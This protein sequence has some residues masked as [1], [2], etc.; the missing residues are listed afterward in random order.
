[1]SIFQKSVV[2]KYLKSLDDE[3]IN[4][5]FERF[6]NFYGNKLRLY[7]ILN[8]KEENYQEGFLR[9][10]FV[11]VLGYTINPDINYNLTTE[12][13]NQTDNKKADG[14]ILK[15]GVAIA[16]I[17]LKSTK[18]PNLESIT[19]QA[20]NYK[21]NQSKCRYVITSNFHSLRFFIDNATEFEEFN[22]FDLSKDEFKRFYLFLS[23]E[24]ILNEIPL[25]LKQETEFHEESISDKFYKDYKTY[26]ENIYSSL[27]KNNTQ[28]D[29]VILY[30]KTQKLLDRILF[31]LFAEDTGLI[32]PNAI[33]RTI[34]KWKVMAN[35][36]MQISLY[37]RFQALFLHLNNG[38]VYPNWGEVPAYNGGLFFPD[39]I[40]DNPDL[41]IENKFLETDSLILAAYDFSSEIDVNILGHIFEHSLNEFEEVA[42]LIQGETI[43]KTKTKRKKDG[44]FYTPKY[45]TK[46]IIE[47]TI[48]SYCS[49]KKN[50]L[51]ISNLEISEKHRKNNKQTKEGK[52]LFAKLS[53]YKE[54]LFNLKIIDPACG[55]GAF[56]IEALH[57]LIS[58]H[59]EIDDKISEL[60]NKT[61]RFF[62]TDKSILEKN[63]YG[64]DI[65]E[66]SV[67]IAKLSLWLNTAKKERKLS[68]LSG[69]IKCG[70]SLIDNKEIAGEKAFDWNLEFPE[71]MQNGGFDIII[72]NP[73][74]VSLIGKHGHNTV[75]EITQ[76]WLINHFGSNT[77]LPNLFEIF[78]I[79]SLSLLKE[80]GF[81]SF[82]V[83]DR[84]G[85]NASFNYL[86]E[87]V[88]QNYKLVEVIYKWD[89][90][91]IITDTMTFVIQNRKEEDYSITIKSEPLNGFINFTK[92]QLLTKQDF[93]F[94]AYKSQTAKSL[95]DKMIASS[96][97][98]REVC[99][100][101]SGFGG[102]SELI[103][104][105]QINTKQ[106]PVFKGSSIQRY[107]IKENY[108][109]E[110]IPENITGRTTDK[111]K[112]SAKP[113]IL[114]R[115]TGNTIIASYDENGVF[116]EQSLYFIYNLNSN[117]DFRYILAILNSDLITWFFIN[118]LVTN[119]D[120]TPQIKL[121]DLDQ[122][123]II[124][125]SIEN[126][127][128]FIDCVDTI[129]KSKQQLKNSDKFVNR[130]TS[131]LKIKSITQ[132]LDEFYK[133]DF[134][135]FIEE[136]EKQKIKLS[137]K[138]SDEWEEYF[139]SYA[140]DLNTANKL[141]I[142]TNEK[143]NN[144]IYALYNLSSD[145][146]M[147]MKSVK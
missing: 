114:V 105:E 1:M 107:E 99:Q 120:S 63:I 36:G 3:K 59:K 134:K 102:K 137:L 35:E 135:T 20:F 27:V 54:W 127:K 109:F 8:L 55:S 131:H 71:I 93:Q 89:F 39:E 77:Y 82:I 75:D 128:P 40:L 53:A 49:I 124:D 132:K 126:Q 16:V 29:K 117:F 52:D 9:E 98:L 78:I 26:K 14:A 32:P 66:E 13:K 97:K 73:P 28:Y 6:T 113:K 15:N 56:L 65:N 12:Y 68:D 81:F 95:I 100:I 69:N 46:Y 30:K 5:A 67:E 83:P 116:P 104:T 112:L 125:M 19:K 85:Y 103:T 123:P 22:L 79:R 33:A 34:E 119:L 45:I 4:Q 106:I 94:K 88:L 25:K 10:I 76:K 41:I 143:L 101:T 136:L 142:E 80:N 144:L 7:N 115:K 140:K 110:F 70:N 122:I 108:W 121:V 50:E 133:Y 17:E 147:I 31:I 61:I 37:T 91:G 57:Y 21:N 23:C 2:N 90:P 145:E 47:K 138:Q 60:E 64:V 51:Q 111:T 24:S 62:D 84:F 38:Y 92:Q 43:D 139:N 74:W 42:A 48:G 18:T 118:Y 129:L 130:I 44:V 87:R 72:G 11:N 96:V 58:E 86:R 141:I 146:I